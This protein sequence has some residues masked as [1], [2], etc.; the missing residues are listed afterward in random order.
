MHPAKN[1]KLARQTYLAC[2]LRR[3][4]GQVLG[5]SL[6]WSNLVYATI[7]SL[8]LLD[9]ILLHTISNI[10]TLHSTTILWHTYTT[11]EFMAISL[12]WHGTKAF[13]SKTKKCTALKR[14]EE[15]IW[16]NPAPPPWTCQWN[17][18]ESFP[19]VQSLL[20]AA[21]SQEQ[22]IKLWLLTYLNKY[23]RTLM[24]P[25]S[26]IKAIIAVFITCWLGSC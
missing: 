19:K 16:S 18:A 21:T 1:I 23:E 3:C 26:F 7:N 5:I 24:S 6:R 10:K 22:H 4:A 11:I 15:R 13:Q 12:I 20:H 17:S 9:I 14:K 25:S 2:L 8:T